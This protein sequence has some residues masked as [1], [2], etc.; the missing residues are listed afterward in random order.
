MARSPFENQHEDDERGAERHG[1]QVLPCLEEKMSTKFF[2]F[3]SAAKLD[4][5]KGMRNRRNQGQRSRFTRVVPEP[6]VLK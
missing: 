5:Q 6:A 3:T 4:T 1:Q 2:P